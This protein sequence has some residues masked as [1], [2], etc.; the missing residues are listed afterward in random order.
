[1]TLHTKHLRAFLAVCREGSVTQAGEALRRAQS[2]ISRS[3]QELEAALG[4]ELFERNARGMLPTEF[5]RILRTRVERAFDELQG[6]RHR[7][8]E[9]QALSGEAPRNAPVFS[10]AVSERRLGVLVAFAERRHMGAVAQMLG[11]S[12]PAVS[13]ALRD[14]EAGV[15]VPLFDRG[16]GGIA[17]TRAGEILLLHIK[18]ALAELRIAASEIAARRGVIEGRVS[19]GALPYGRPYMLPVAIARVLTR[20]PGLRVTTIEGRFETLATGLRSGDID[21]V[22]GALGPAAQDGEW[23]REEL[24]RESMAIIA[25]ADHSLARR[26]DL[27]LRDILEVEWTLSASGTP[28]RKVLADSLDAMGL[29]QPRVAVESSD[30]SIIRGL[31]L[32][33]DMVSAGS[34]HLFQYELAAGDLVT[35]PVELPGTARPIGI[36]SRT[37]SHS[38][39]GAKLLI[40]ELRAVADELL[41]PLHRGSPGTTQAVTSR[42]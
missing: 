16:V 33:T 1:V 9:L 27:T 36:L 11:V 42:A 30:L 19:V 31:L 23:A 29:P 6:A 21:F 41:D 20:H 18:R 22:L 40:D 32:E 28:T 37:Q 26:A 17:L 15:G 12:Q 8:A 13:M 5:G 10:L 35:L 4:V 24:F 38:S 2:A 39:P 14:L 25:R 7:M 34:R 3:V